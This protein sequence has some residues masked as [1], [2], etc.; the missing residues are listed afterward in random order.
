MDANIQPDLTCAGSH[1]IA[2]VDYTGFDD[3][4]V[5]RG[6]SPGA[7][8]PLTTRARTNV[9]PSRAPILILC[10]PQRVRKNFKND[11]YRASTVNVVKRPQASDYGADK[12]LTTPT[13]VSQPRPVSP[14]EAGGSAPFKSGQQPGPITR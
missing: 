14:S 4:Q 9:G 3:D 6:S 1:L 10:S 2:I 7:A 8:R 12:H 13:D 5:K 11:R